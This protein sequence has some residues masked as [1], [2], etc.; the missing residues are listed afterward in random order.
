M[1]GRLAQSLEARRPKMLSWAIAG[2][3]ESGEPGLVR[4]RVPS[5]PGYWGTFLRKGNT[6]AM[7]KDRHLEDSPES[8]S[9][10]ELANT[11]N[12]G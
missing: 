2:R 6:D 5:T 9:S 10:S 12:V 3:H 4:V 8:A 11:L 1:L 7:A